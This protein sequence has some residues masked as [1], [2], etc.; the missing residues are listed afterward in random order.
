MVDRAVTDKVKIR[1]GHIAHA[2]DAQLRQMAA[3]G[4]DEDSNIGSNIVTKSIGLVDEHPLLRQLYYGVR[5]GKK[6][7]RCC[8]KWQRPGRCRAT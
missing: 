7:R 6:L 3:M 2:T 5:T 1:L 4:S 8:L